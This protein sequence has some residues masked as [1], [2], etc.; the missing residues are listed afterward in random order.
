[1][2]MSELVCFPSH[3]GIYSFTAL[4]MMMMIIFILLQ[5]ICSTLTIAEHNVKLFIKILTNEDALELVI[6][7]WINDI[8]RMP[9]WTEVGGLVEYCGIKHVGSGICD[10][11]KTGTLFLF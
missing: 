6:A 1:M 10:V 11:Y 2:K 7:L 8:G 5:N 4:H 3:T 9:R